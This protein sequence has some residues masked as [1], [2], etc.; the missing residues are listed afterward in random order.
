MSS[1]LRPSHP[2]VLSLL[3][4]LGLS[5]HGCGGARP[6]DGAEGDGTA[7]SSTQGSTSTGA[8]VPTGG[9][10]FDPGTTDPGTTDPTTTAPVTATASSSGSDSDTG[11]STGDPPCAQGTI[12]CDGEVA[13]VCDGAG[14]F[15][16]EETCPSDC[17]PDLGC[18]ACVPGEGVCDGNVASKC[19]A[20]GSGWVDSF[21]DDVQGLTCDA[22]ECVGACAPA[23]LGASHLGCEFYSVVTPSAVQTAFTFAVA[24]SN[25]SAEDADVTITRGADPVVDILVPAN[26]SEVIPLPWVL[27][28]KG[29]SASQIVADGA[30]RI[31][32]TR[33]VAVHQ[34]TPLEYK[35]QG[36]Q[37][38]FNEASLLM[39]SNAYG[40]D[41]VAIARNTL[42]ANPGVYVVVA[43]EDGTTINVTPSATGGII[44]AGGGIAAD[45]TGMAVL[46]A[47]DVLQVMSGVGGGEPDMP[48]KADITG[49]RVA[50]DKPVM[51]LG[52]HNCTYVPFDAC[53]CDPLVE[54]NLPTANLARD[55]LVTT[56]LVKAANQ[57]PVVKARMVRIVATA[58]ATTLTYDP[59]QDGAP[60]ALAKA[61][62]FAELQTDENFKVSA[63]FKIAV[64]EYLLS[65]EAGGGG[66]GDPAMTIA[67]PIEQ[68]RSSYAFHAP[69]NYESNFVN[70]IA[71]TGAE[72][73]LDGQP[74]ADFQAIGATGFSVARVLLANDG[75]GDHTL[76]G[77]APFGVQVY[78]YGQYV[79]YAYPGG[80]DLDVIPP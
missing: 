9:G 74:V 75:D 45:G 21:C 65:Q 80:L 13:K 11:S 79:S 23:S 6:D 53:C 29:I 15:E 35:K 28:L 42:N 10:T 66:A 54:L 12:V 14:G 67:V 55:Y 57:T 32:S 44:K 4:V 26:S 69:T 77:D 73:V 56:P 71:P 2:R 78:G 33:P 17:A 20:E 43:R 30:Y 36:L 59:P 60:A 64:S 34:Y 22:G 37:S 61:G 68:Y 8:T 70:I 31:R 51:V 38:A 62:D 48:D 52:A 72:V 24:V 27:E 50:S 63:N 58:D 3:W 18:V 7:A 19:D 41:T 5:S 39:P 76:T 25:L 16:S 47:G 1:L 46:D 49:T 40:T